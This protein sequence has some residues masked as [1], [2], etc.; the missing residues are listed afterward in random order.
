MKTPTSSVSGA[1]RLHR[2]FTCGLAIVLS[3]LWLAGCE[4]SV[5]NQKKA[6]DTEQGFEHYFVDDKTLRFDYL[7][8]GDRDTESVAED[9]L[10]WQPGWAGLKENLVDP[11]THASYRL[12]MRDKATGRAIYGKSFFA[13]LREYKISLT[14]ENN[15]LK[16]YH[17]TLLMPFP[18]QA[19]TVEI[20]FVDAHRENHRIFTGDFSAQRLQ[21]VKQRQVEPSV[22]V[23]VGDIG[24]RAK[25]V[26]LVILAEGYRAEEQDKFRTDLAR[27]VADFFTEEPYSRYRDAF[28]VT[29]IFKASADSGLD[30]PSEGDFRD[31]VLGASLDMLGL[32]RLLGSEDNRSIRDMAGAV[33]YDYAVV[34]VNSDVWA[35]SGGYNNMGFAT[36]D[37]PNGHALFVHEFAHLFAGLADEYYVSGVPYNDYYPEGTEPPEPNITAN[38]DAATIKWQH[39]LSE[40]I[41]VPTPWD[42]KKYESITH[43]REALNHFFASHEMADKV[44]AFAGAGYTDTLFRPAADCIMFRAEAP[45]FCP[46]CSH[47]LEAFI[48]YHSGQSHENH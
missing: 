8:T 12:T 45:R 16:S 31:T 39:F 3:A 32:P 23:P 21:A 29:G 18:K 17:Q 25:R 33:P 34:L 38:A 5:Q 1:A 41:P 42:Q 40:G 26:D 36:S 35:G 46:V 15:A 19:V 44:G 30:D 27:M 6:A 28:N 20:D 22:I 43:D 11:F 37:H 4:R 47:T 7:H 14:A 9:S 10:Y 24:D 2:R 48:L 13:D